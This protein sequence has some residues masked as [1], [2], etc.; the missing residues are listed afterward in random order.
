MPDEEKIDFYRFLNEYLNDARI[1]FQRTNTA[2]LTLEKDYA[3]IEKL[4]EVSRA[5]HTLKSSSAMLG[6]TEISDLAHS[7][8]DLLAKI[9]T[10]EIPVTRDVIDL[11]FE[12]IDTLENM[13][14]KRGKPLTPS[15]SPQ[16]RGIR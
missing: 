12:I 4:D 14:K 11:I 9:K 16:R 1:G 2:L 13:V 8:E 10:N 15:L 6:F 7:S 5:I 3:K